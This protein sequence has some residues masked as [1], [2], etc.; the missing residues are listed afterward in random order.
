MFGRSVKATLWLCG[1][2]IATGQ[3][4]VEVESEARF[5]S[6]QL[7]VKVVEQRAVTILRLV[8]PA[9]TV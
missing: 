5:R 6:Q 2:L 9:A 7:G 3:E 1:R 8:K 4:C